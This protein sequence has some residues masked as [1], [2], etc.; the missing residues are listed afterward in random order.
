MLGERGLPTE[1]ANPKVY[2]DYTDMTD[3]NSIKMGK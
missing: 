2:G 1:F 3:A